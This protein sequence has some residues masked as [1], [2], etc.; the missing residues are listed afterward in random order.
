MMIAI[1]DGLTENPSQ[2]YTRHIWIEAFFALF[3]VFLGVVRISEPFIWTNIKAD[4]SL[5]CCKNKKTERAKFSKQSL[6]SFL[7][8]AMNIE[9]VYVLLLSL[10][11]YFGECMQY[12]QFQIEKKKDEVKISIIGLG[13][14]SKWD[15]TGGSV[16]SE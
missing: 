5:M 7:N 1:F 10:N 2:K 4:F 14:E 8:S 16:Y 3:G 12:D 9:Y 6:D 13:N 15:V 11:K